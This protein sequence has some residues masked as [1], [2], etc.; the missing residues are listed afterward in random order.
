MDAWTNVIVARLS[1]VINWL[2][3]PASRHLE[4]R[5]ELIATVIQRRP[6]VYISCT[7][8][9]MMSLAAALI[10]RE[11]W[12]ISWFA[13]DSLLIGYRLY[14]SWRH[15]DGVNEPREKNGVVLATMFLLFILFGL[16]SA[17]SI[18][19]G[20]MVLV[21]MAIISVLGIF[22]GLVSRWA[23]FPRLA[24]LTI[25]AIGLPVG[26]AILFRSQASFLLAAIQFLAIAISIASQTIQ[27]H[28]TLIRM[29]LA[30]HENA[31][32]ARSDALTGLG[33]RVRLAEELGSVLT[34]EK[35]RAAILY[36]DLDGFKTF[37]DAHGHQA[38]DRLLQKVSREIR[39]QVGPSG[40]VYRI[41]GDEFVIL[42]GNKED[43]LVIQLADRVIKAVA[44]TSL[45]PGD[46]QAGVRISAGIAFA[47]S[48]ETPSDLLKRA[49]LALYDAKKGGKSRYCLADETRNLR[50]IAA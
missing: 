28:R 3:A 12:A 7:A 46:P 49:D 43:G 6:A 34:E 17:M 27:N 19:T 41:G 20:P 39:S 21:L 8:L 40:S 11:A 38:G 2:L 36:L 25:G 35:A 13:I 4:V 37:N 24:L 9:T 50:P 29:M 26:L 30:E 33:N 18:A 48:G 45:R 42:C 22:A 23:A 15:D 14:L 1:P 31:K 32:L 10:T 47:R 44:L 5:H 16:G